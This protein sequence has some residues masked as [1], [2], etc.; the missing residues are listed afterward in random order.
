VKVLR[1]TENSDENIFQTL[2][3]YT[4]VSEIYKQIGKQSESEKLM[5]I[6]YKKFIDQVKSIRSEV[7][8][9]EDPYS[10]E[11]RLLLAAAYAQAP[12]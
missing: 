10:S 1:N 6:I 12:C 7:K 8:G 5:N 3:K 11:K 9:L 4:S 2:E